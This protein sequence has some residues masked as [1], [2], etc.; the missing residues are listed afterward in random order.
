MITSFAGGEHHAV[1]APKLVR[2]LATL[3]R[4]D[5]VRLAASC[6]SLSS[7]LFSALACS[8]A[9]LARLWPNAWTRWQR[10]N[11]RYL[12]VTFAASHGLHA[13]AIACCAASEPRG[14]A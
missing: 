6:R 4:A 5:A 14:S 13:I 12:G 1:A 2:R 3:R 7:L 8:A 10:R 11:R 9:A